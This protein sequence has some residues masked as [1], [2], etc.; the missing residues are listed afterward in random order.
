MA[1]T[2]ADFEAVPQTA[3]MPG[4]RVTGSR[5]ELAEF[6][7]LVLG[8]ALMAAGFLAVAAA[9]AV[10]TLLRDVP[11][12]IANAG[13]RFAFADVLVRRDFLETTAFEATV[14]W[15]LVFMALLWCRS[16]ARRH[17]TAQH[18]GGRHGD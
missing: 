17:S 8:T 6:V 4:D 3:P 10:A 2:Y 14:I 16:A 11:G 13:L 18:T 15:A 7:R 5:R 1:T 12:A 9:V